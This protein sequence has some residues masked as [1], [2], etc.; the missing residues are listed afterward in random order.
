[1]SKPTGGN[2]KGPKAMSKTEI[3][4]GLAEKTGLSKKQIQEVLDALTEMIES[5]VSKRARA[6]SRFPV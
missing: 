3:L 6:R 2:S 4:A 1:M 5:S